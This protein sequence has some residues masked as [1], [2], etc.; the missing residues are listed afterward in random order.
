MKSMHLLAGM[1]RRFSGSILM[2]A[3]LMNPVAFADGTSG[4]FTIQE[5]Q[6]PAG[7]DGAQVVHGIAGGYNPDGCNTNNRFVVSYSGDTPDRARAMV[8]AAMMAYSLG[9]TAKAYV[10]GCAIGAGGSTFP[11]VRILYVIN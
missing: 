7:Y 11:L 9:K 6:F 4:N 3:V 10:N 8:A 2:S 1:L 5:M